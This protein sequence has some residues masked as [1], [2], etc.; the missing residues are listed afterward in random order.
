MPVR[1][2]APAAA[3]AATA[4]SDRASPTTRRARRCAR[5][6]GLGDPVAW[7]TAEVAI[8]V[9]RT[10]FERWVDA[11]ADRDFPQFVRDSLAQ[12]KTLTAS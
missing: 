7:L 4:V 2:S 1:T 3:S 9:F 5:R 6:R 10:A 11:A 12:L 8:A